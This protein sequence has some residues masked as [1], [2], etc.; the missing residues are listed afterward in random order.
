VTA[1][2]AMIRTV[3]RKSNE[4]NLDTYSDEDIVEFIEAY[5][6]IDDQG[7]N[8]WYISGNPPE[9][10]V[11]IGWIPTYDLNAA[12]ANIWEEKASVVGQDFDFNADGGSYSRSQVYQQYMETVRYF[13]SKRAASTIQVR[14]Q[15]RQ[16]YYEAL[17]WI[18]NLAELDT[19]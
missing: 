17:Q 2:E 7:L 9:R 10:K 12:I 5:P 4:D 18:G 14:G 15:P 6:L 8:P 19:K 3:R 1:T 16:S 11:T 13:R